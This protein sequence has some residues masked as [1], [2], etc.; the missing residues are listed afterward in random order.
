ML[1]HKREN[2]M[3]TMWEEI[4]DILH[5]YDVTFSIGDGLRP[6]GL[7][8]ATDKAQLAE[9]S[10]LGELTERAWRKGVQVMVEGPGH[11]PFDQ[12]EYNMKLQRQ[13]CHGAPF[14]VLGPLVTDIF[15]GYDHITSCI[16]ATAAGYHGAAMLCYVTPK[17]HLG[18]PKKEDVKQGCVAYKIAAHAADIALGIPGARNRDDELTKARAALNWEKH[19]ELSFD[20]DLARAYHD[21]D[22]GVD[23]NF[24]A[25]CG[26]DWC[27]VRISKE[28]NEF[29]SGKDKHYAWDKVKVSPAKRLEVSPGE[30]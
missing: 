4:C 26:H 10:T 28:I 23:T 21:E 27:S 19:F 20:P 7:A 12:I 14:Y 22:L 3:Y 2:L 9:L 29:D 6:G 1:T 17:E 25:M 8:D 16:G 18:L 24:C 11:V 13:L 30:D 5:E 15:P